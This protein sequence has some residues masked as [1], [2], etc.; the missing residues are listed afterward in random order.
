M[1]AHGHRGVIDRC[2]MRARKSEPVIL[3]FELCA[4]LLDLLETREMSLCGALA[5]KRIACRAMLGC[6][7]VCTLSRA[8]HRRHHTNCT[9]VRDHYGAKC[10]V[11]RAYPAPNERSL[12]YRFRTQSTYNTQ[13][14]LQAAPGAQRDLPIKG[15]LALV[16]DWRGCTW[17]GWLA[18]RVVGRKIAMHARALRALTSDSAPRR[19]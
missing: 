12:Q 17:G 5:G 7:G 10:A 15:R 1:I 19:R 4:G 13:E 18:M 16:V 8:V 3:A 14:P 11:P 2:R 9:D 6:M